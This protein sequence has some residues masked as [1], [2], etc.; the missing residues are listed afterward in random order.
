MCYVVLVFHIY[1]L[2]SYEIDVRFFIK[3]RWEEEAAAPLG[4]YS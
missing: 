3:R 2:E 4:S 1:F